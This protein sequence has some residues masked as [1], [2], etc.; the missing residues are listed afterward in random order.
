MSGTWTIPLAMVVLLASCGSDGGSGGTGDGSETGA[1][2]VLRDDFSDTSVGWLGPGETSFEGEN[3]D[4][5][6]ADG[7]LRIFVKTPGG[8]GGPD[9]T[10][11]DVEGPDALE[12]LGDVFVEVTAERTTNPGGHLY[13]V[14]CRMQDFDNFYGFVVV[15][16][17]RFSI[18]KIVRGVAT[19][20]ISGP[21]DAISTG[22]VGSNRLRA[23]CLGTTLTMFID[24][25]RVA[26]TQDDQFSAGA[27]GFLAETRGEAGLEVFFDDL[28]VTR[29]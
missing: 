3:V 18:F 25:Q 2:I 9:S 7:R 15:E 5:E 1:E 22:E 11:L 29:P 10:S 20:L 23:D 24:G 19:D 21:S 13:G 12:S 16:P 6:I 28:A 27:I 26:T 17:G 14:L 4:M 8:R